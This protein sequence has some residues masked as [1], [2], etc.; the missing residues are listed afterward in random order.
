MLLY[1]QKASVTTSTFNTFNRQPLRAL[2][3]G[4]MSL[5]EIETKSGVSRATSSHSGPF[6]KDGGTTQRVLWAMSLIWGLFPRL[7]WLTGWTV[8]FIKEL[9]LFQELLLVYSQGLRLQ[10]CYS[11]FLITL[12]SLLARPLFSKKTMTV[13]AVLVM[14]ERICCSRK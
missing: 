10:S 6:K 1:V 11:R 5:F 13:P 8:L 12:Y 9:M 3:L 14:A 7:Y 2:L 4:D